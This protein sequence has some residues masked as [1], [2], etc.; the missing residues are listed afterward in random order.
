VPI[1]EDPEIKKAIKKQQL[2]NPDSTVADKIKKI[3]RA[4]GTEKK[5]GKGKGKKGKGAGGDADSPRNPELPGNEA[6]LNEG[7]NAEGEEKKDEPEDDTVH[8]KKLKKNVES[9]DACT[10]TDR[11]DYMLIK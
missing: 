6:D 4:D 8:K 1:L 10:Q 2:E 3:A 9:K 11:S 7:V 5:K